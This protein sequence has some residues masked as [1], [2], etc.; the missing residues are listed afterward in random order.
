MSQMR[1]ARSTYLPETTK[2]DAT[3]MLGGKGRRS[4]TR[5]RPSRPRLRHQESTNQDKDTISREAKKEP[6]TQAPNPTMVFLAATKNFFVR[7]K[8]PW[9][10]KTVETKPDHRGGGIWVR[11]SVW[12]CPSLSSSTTS[13]CKEGD[14]EATK[15]D[16][17][18]RSHQ[19]IRKKREKTKHKESSRREV[20]KSKANS[21]WILKRRTK[22]TV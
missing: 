19:P 12:F 22:Q 5:S 17:A 16:E 11:V 14:G 18:R 10:K 8:I 7:K 15:L 2:T 4:T 21:N 3:L 13:V 9:C 20:K 1:R 6:N